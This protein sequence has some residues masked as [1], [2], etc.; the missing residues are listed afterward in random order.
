MFTLLVCARAV[1]AHR[2]GYRPSPQVGTIQADGEIVHHHHHFHDG[3]VSGIVSAESA[4][5]AKGVKCNK[6]LRHWCKAH[7]E[8]E[9]N[10]PCQ[11]ECDPNMDYLLYERTGNRIISYRKNTADSERVGPCVQDAAR[12]TCNTFV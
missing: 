2:H 9:L 1:L 3:K 12:S 4:K 10:K 5:F 6:L 11:I 8:M 7:Y